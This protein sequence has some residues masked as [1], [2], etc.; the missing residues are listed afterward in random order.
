MKN[1]GKFALKIAFSFWLVT[2][3]L[4]ATIILLGVYIGMGV[5]HGLNSLNFYIPFLAYLGACF[6]SFT[7]FLLIGY[8]LARTQNHIFADGKRINFEIP[9]IEIPYS[10]IKRIK[11]KKFFLI[12]IINIDRG[13]GFGT[14]KSMVFESNN[15]MNKF[16]VDA[17]L[18]QFVVSK[19]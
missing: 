4:I 16:L 11:T 12:Y 17:N 18:I 19:K 8:S 7:L 14:D 3:F 13:L 15:E 5:A 2:A 6:S 9:S 1:N 10:Q